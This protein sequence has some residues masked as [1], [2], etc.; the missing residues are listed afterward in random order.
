MTNGLWHKIVTPELGHKIRDEMVIL[1]SGAFGTIGA[2][3]AED[4]PQ[5][6]FVYWI[7]DGFW[8]ELSTS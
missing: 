5:M 6:F 4:T 7:H 3:R 8:Y 2:W 1:A